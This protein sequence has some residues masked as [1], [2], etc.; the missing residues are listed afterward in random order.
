MSTQVD[1]IEVNGAA[2][3]IASQCDATFALQSRSEAKR[4]ATN[5]LLKQ[6]NW[7]KQTKDGHADDAARHLI[8]TVLKEFPEAYM[9]LLESI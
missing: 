4:I 6:L 9:E 2:R 5:Q 8:L 7:R 1:A 3:W